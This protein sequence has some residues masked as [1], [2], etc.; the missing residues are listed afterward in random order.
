MMPFRDWYIRN[1]A[2]GNV[3]LGNSEFKLVPFKEGKG[4]SRGDAAA[5]K[6]V[7]HLEVI[8]ALFICV[9]NTKVM[10]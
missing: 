9:P 1:G 8:N 4:E 7:K 6:K 10:C 3:S 5:A 2:L